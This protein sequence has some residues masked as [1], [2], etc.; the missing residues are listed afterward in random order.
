M[1]ANEM[2]DDASFEPDEDVPDDTDTATNV[3]DSESTTNPIEVLECPDVDD[4]GKFLG[5]H[6]SLSADDNELIYQSVGDTRDECVQ[7]MLATLNWLPECLKAVESGNTELADVV[8]IEMTESVVS[9]DK[10]EEEETDE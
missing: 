5:I 1:T 3:H 10:N 7:D 2:D 4:D 6:R 8:P 9:D